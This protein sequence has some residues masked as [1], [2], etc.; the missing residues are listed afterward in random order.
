MSNK[1]IQIET[2]H[3]GVQQTTLAD[4]ELTEVL[5][6]SDQIRDMPRENLSE[7]FVIIFDSKPLF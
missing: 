5:Q 6:K 3:K 2:V 1:S 4:K 7:R